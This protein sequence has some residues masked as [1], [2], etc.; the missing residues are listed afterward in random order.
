M[1]SGTFERFF[2]FLIVLIL[3]VLVLI[4]SGGLLFN[5]SLHIDEGYYLGAS[6]A[7]LDG[8]ILLRSYGF[9]KPFLIALWPL[10]GLLLFGKQAL[11]FR[12][13]P[14]VCYLLALLVFNRLLKRITGARFVA[15]LGTAM[16]F[17]L[18]IFM[19]HAI[20][21]FCEP[22]L[23]LL[24]ILLMYGVFSG[25]S[26]AFL[27]RIFF[28]GVF[29]K[30]SFLLYLPLLVP[31]IRKEGS[32]AF[33]RPSGWIFVA[34]LIY[35]VANPNKFASIT[36]FSHFVQDPHAGAWISRV[37]DRIQLIA[38]AF[39][40]PT[41]LIL[42]A[43]SIGLF[44]KNAKWKSSGELR[45][46]PW[47]LGLHLFVFL[48]M[49]AN[50]YQ[51]YV[52]Q[53]LPVVFVMGAMGVASITE[54]TVFKRILQFG[55]AVGSLVAVGFLFHAERKP[56]AEDLAL[57]RELLLYASEVDHEGAWVQN[58][59]LW[60]T[61]PFHSRAIQSGCVGESCTLSFRVAHPLFQNG[62]EFAGGRL[63][64]SPLWRGDARNLKREVMEIPFQADEIVESL[65]RALHLGKTYYAT[66]IEFEASRAASPGDLFS[67]TG[68]RAEL[69]PIPSKSSLFPKLSVRFMVGVHEFH[70]GGEVVPLPMYRLLVRI[71]EFRVGDRDFVDVL[72]VFFKGHVVEIGVLPYEY[73][74]NV[75]YSISRV[76]ERSL[77]LVKET[78]TAISGR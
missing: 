28:L 54:G 63:K 75:R 27:S 7:I 21:N 15:V 58:G 32:K 62:Y 66:R 5:P 29:T 78:V 35:M 55:F 34:A 38:G 39:G 41:V 13:V 68:L 76:N 65:A 10:P 57:G 61:A 47:V 36:W 17:F 23:I 49:S 46:L 3:F 56:V 16:L 44:L 30:Y 42:V 31:R 25:A 20:S 59:Y 52:V 40:S 60:Q 4:T 18:P 8:D 48:F 77:E 73:L 19:V 6:R 43:V 9:D 74:P 70:Q 1:K 26:T 51:R 24:A 37:W 2:E 14:F 33:L 50:F 22:Y 69:S 67:P 11:G 72:P 53:V 64:R 12:L 71:E 45:A